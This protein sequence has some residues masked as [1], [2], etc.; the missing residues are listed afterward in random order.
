KIKDISCLV[1]DNFRTNWVFA[2]ATLEDGTQGFGEATLIGTEQ[3][4]AS[5]ISLWGPRL[6]G[7]S[8]LN[9]SALQARVQRESYWLVGPVI[10]SALS[11]IDTALWDAKARLLGVPVYALLGGKVRDSVPVYANGW[12]VGAK[13]A[14]EFAEK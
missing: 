7:E 2:V 8:V 6:V 4:V 12:F 13:S 3:A 9:V 14:S 5:M 1:V 11:A 10:S